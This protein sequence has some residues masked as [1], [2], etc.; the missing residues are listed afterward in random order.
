MQLGHGYVLAKSKIQSM[1]ALDIKTLT[2]IYPKRVYAQ[3]CMTC[4]A[5]TVITST[6][7]LHLHPFPTS[8]TQY[9]THPLDL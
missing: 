4:L 3:E 9:R 7:Y 6:K 2:Q 1:H 5:K 8:S